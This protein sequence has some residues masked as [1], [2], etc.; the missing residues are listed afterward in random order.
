M[1]PA[2][3]AWLMAG[4]TF[5]GAGVT[6][7]AL[8]AN[9]T[10]GGVSQTSSPDFSA[11]TVLFD[12]FIASVGDNA[13][14]DLEVP[15]NPLG[16]GVVAVYSADYRGFVNDGD[17]LSVVVAHNGTMDGTVVVGPPDD[18]YFRHYI[19]NTGDSLDSSITLALTNYTDPD[20]FASLDSIDYLEVGRT[21]MDSVQASVAEHSAGRTALV[22][23]LRTTADLMNGLLQ[24][25]S[26]PSS[27]AVFGSLGSSTFGATGRYSSGDGFSVN[28]GVAVLNHSPG[29]TNASG[30]LVSGSVRYT[31]PQ[32]DLLRPYAEIGA[33]G[34][35]NLDLTFSRNYA[36][37][38]AGGVDVSSSTTGSVYGGYIEGGVLFSAAEG[39]EVALSGSLGEDWLNLGA[40]SEAFSAGN[41]FS[42]SFDESSSRFT[43]AKLGVDW[44]MD[45]TDQIDLTLTG[46]VGKTFAHDATTANVSFIGPVT[47]A[48][49]DEFFGRYGAR[50][51][52][53]VTE[54]TR[55]EAFAL[56]NT[57][58]V[59]GT[60]FQLGSSVRFHF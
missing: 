21:S 34:A 48:G 54:S 57:G 27:V 4:V 58:Q 1:K 25:A 39:T 23:D 14:C 8:A 35:P 45:M 18:P 51:G 36:S 2:L 38:S 30:V 6:G 42:A 56:G 20:T 17:A 16:P 13:T 5:A 12:A 53:A 24:P 11:Y 55:V 44:T 10:D 19:A 22:T 33:H 59:S 26:A 52:W 37:N 29:N 47:T 60:Q 32:Y 7:T 43:T 49:A 40:S 50:L 46:S 9:C 41:L 31:T 15:I 3:S 28:G